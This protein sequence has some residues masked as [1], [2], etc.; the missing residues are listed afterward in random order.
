MK[1]NYTFGMC[2]FCLTPHQTRNKFADEQPK[3]ANKC[4]N[5]IAGVTA[6]AIAIAKAQRTLR[7]LS[8]VQHIKTAFKT[9]QYN[10]EWAYNF[11]RSFFSSKQR[12]LMDFFPSFGS[13]RFY[14]TSISAPFNGTN[15]REYI[16]EFYVFAPFLFSSK[17]C[18]IKT[19]IKATIF[20]FFLSFFPTFL[21]SIH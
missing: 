8:N 20:A 21:F 10:S 12:A 4:M 2:L 13:M 14:K 5:R 3:R 7:L 6:I 11:F 18:Y 16:V 17:N 19:L 9:L 1:C 15:H